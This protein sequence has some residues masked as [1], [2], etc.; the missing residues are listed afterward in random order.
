MGDY[1]HQNRRQSA[2]VRHGQELSLR[3]VGWMTRR[4]RERGQRKGEKSGGFEIVEKHPKKHTACLHVARAR[5]AGTKKRRAQRFPCCATS[6]FYNFFFKF[7][8]NSWKKW[9]HIQKSF[10]EHVFSTK[11]AFFVLVFLPHAVSRATHPRREK[12]IRVRSPFHTEN[13]FWTQKTDDSKIKI[14]Y[15]A[16]RFLSFRNHE[17]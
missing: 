5:G 11:R 3:N 16:L 7:K 9:R 1:A 2:A 14:F 8:Q 15:W 13:Y 17:F 12:S 10:S 6:F 4:R